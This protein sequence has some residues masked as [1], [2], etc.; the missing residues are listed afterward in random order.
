MLWSIFFFPCQTKEVAPF[1]NKF[2]DF[3]GFLE[4]KYVFPNNSHLLEKY[5]L[6]QIDVA[7]K[8]KK[9]L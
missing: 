5:Y 2:C 3:H 6:T 7:L 8:K 4:E 9:L 1:F